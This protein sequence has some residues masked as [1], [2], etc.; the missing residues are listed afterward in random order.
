MHNI[1]AMEYKKLCRLFIEKI[2]KN[3]GYIY[4]VDYISNWKNESEGKCPDEM[5]EQKETGKDHIK[6]YLSP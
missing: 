3:T 2:E 4:V 1:M 6:Q 5:Q